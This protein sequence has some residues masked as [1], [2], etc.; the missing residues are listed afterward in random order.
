MKINIF[1]L[2]SLKLKL[3]P[4]QKTRISN[5]IKVHATKAGKMFRLKL[6]NFT[7]SCD[8]DKYKVISQIGMGA[9]AMDESWINITVNPKKFGIFI[10]KYLPGLI[11]HEASHIFRGHFNQYGRTL[12][13]TVVSEGLAIVLEEENIPNLT[14]LYGIYS[15]KSILKY[16][17]TFKKKM[18]SKKFN[19]SEWFFGTGKYP[20]WLGYYIGAYIVRKAKENNPDLTADKL[21]SKPADYILKLSKMRSL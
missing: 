4:E 6:L 14:V 8:D 7:V 18:H 2:E 13:Q 5:V 9:S 12:L 3:S 16:I 21:M 10:E 17:S 1:F 20:N 11:Y 15:E 19:Y